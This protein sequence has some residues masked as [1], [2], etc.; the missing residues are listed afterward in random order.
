MAEESRLSQAELHLVETHHDVEAFFRWLGE[1]RPV[2]GMDTE[3]EG[4][5]Y[6]HMDVRTVQFGDPAHGWTLP[7]EWWAGAVREVFNTYEGPMT[8]HNAPFDIRF[9]ERAGYKLPPFIHDTYVMAH[10]LDPNRPL[11]QK[12]LAKKFLDPRAD[13]LQ[14][15]LHDGMR[16]QKWTWATV[17]V[18]W[19]PYWAYSALDPVE[20]ALLFEL[21]DP[22][23]DEMRDQYER[24][25]RV[26]RMMSDAS[27]TGLLI[28][29]EYAQEEMDRLWREVKGIGARCKEE[30]GVTPTNLAAVA[31]RLVADG[32]RLTE[33]TATGKIKMTKDIM[34]SLEGQHP[35][36]DLVQE[37]RH[38][39]KF[40]KA[41]FGST[42]DRLDENDVIHCEVRTLGARTGRMSV[43]KPALQ[44]IP[45]KDVSVRR[46]FVTRPG[47][48]FISIDFSNIEPRVL[49]HLCA[50]PT[51]VDALL[52]GKDLHLEMAKKMYGEGAGDAERKKSKSGCVPTD[53]P[54][55]TQRGWLSHEDVRVGD[56][57][58]GLNTATGQTEWTTI[59]EVVVYPDAEVVALEHSRRQLAVCT[60]DHRWVTR[61]RRT[62]VPLRLE[63]LHDIP[64]DASLVLAAPG[65]APVGEC[66][67]SAA[68]AGLLAWLHTDGHVEWS[69]CTSGRTAQAGG[70]KRG[71]KATVS[72][73]RRRGV[74][75]IRTLEQEGLLRFSH[76]TPSGCGVWAAAPAH[77]RDLWERSGLADGG[78][79]EALVLTL[80][81]AGVTEFVEACEAAD[82]FTDPQRATFTHR[83]SDILRA[84]LLAAW[85]LG[86]WA[87]V[88]PH[89]ESFTA[90]A[91]RPGFSMQTVRRTPAGRSDVWCVRTALGSWTTRPPG[92]SGPM[93]TGNTLGEIYGI[94]VA[95]FA[96]QQKLTERQAE[97][98]KAFYAETFPNVMDFKEYVTAVAQQR[99]RDEGVAYVQLPGGR[100]HQLT[101]QEAVEWRKFYVLVNY[102]CQGTA[103]EI[104]KDRIVL[105]QDAG[106]SQ[107]IRLPVH[108]ELLL[109]VPH[110]LVADVARAARDIMEDRTL[111]T[112]SV[113]I[114]C[115]VEIYPESWAQCISGK[116][117]IEEWEA[118]NG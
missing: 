25:I 106:L 86:R 13:L 55:L 102:I 57:T 84:Y 116:L 15:A 103:A 76:R 21:M 112:W 85:R 32:V 67:V 75:H 39:L 72:Q 4:L 28:D 83:D 30:F 90:T 26:D 97:E 50:D 81:E 24:E 107:Y 78:T 8:G 23:M 33:R 49:A 45:S 36:V 9:L 2:L 17:P 19:A 29:R 93:L 79:L 94:G 52:A 68:E 16:K 65:L 61:R 113:P 56:L 18:D 37:Y 88:S 87:R 95:K 96:K 108:D 59:R 62:D 43:A 111:T 35:L 109:E 69:P 110:D 44:Q 114:T 63:H 73:Q 12:P 105:L 98:F 64:R 54:I 20:A 66:R 14:K 77:I 41:Y 22:Q 27:V 118:L 58:P 38:M 89:A 100:K 53:Y 5:E 1:R 48:A 101:H 47:N 70:S 117:S 82:G 71:V 10:L 80:P 42:L 6:W 104:L 91:K 11:G 60:P 34:D 99:L 46:M 51:M 7:L 115:D 3:S 74:A 92:V 31:D 40:H